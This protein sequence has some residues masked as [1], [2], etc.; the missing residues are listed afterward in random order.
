MNFGALRSLLR[1]RL[2]DFRVGD[3][4]PNWSDTGL[5]EIINLG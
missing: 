4:T 2:H 1:R 3:N 5:S